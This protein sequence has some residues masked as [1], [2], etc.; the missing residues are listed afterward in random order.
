MGHKII[1]GQHSEIHSVVDVHYDNNP[2]SIYKMVAQ[3]EDRS[4]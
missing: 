3:I 4:L 1:I 2:Y